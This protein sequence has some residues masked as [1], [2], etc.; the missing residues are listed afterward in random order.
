M[1]SCQVLTKKNTSN[2]TKQLL[3]ENEL[4]KFRTFYLGYFNGKSH[5]EEDGT[6]HYLVFPPIVRYFKVNTITSTDYISSWKPKGLSVGS[7]KPPTTSDNSLT[8]TLSYYDQLKVRVTFT[9]SCLKQPKFRHT[10]KTIVN[11]YIVYEMGAFTSNEVVITTAQLH[12]TKPE[13]RF[14]TGSNP[15]GGVSEIRDD[16]DLWQ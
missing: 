6:Q 4:N 5:F 10:D 16:E 13:L 2:K 14:C 3:V 8:P 7:I 11:I 9:K 15:A 12:S 1:S